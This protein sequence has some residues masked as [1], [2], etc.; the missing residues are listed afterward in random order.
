MKPLLTA[1][2]IGKMCRD[3]AKVYGNSDR[4]RAL[5]RMYLTALENEA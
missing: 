4:Y 1:D 3:E 2:Q 5:L